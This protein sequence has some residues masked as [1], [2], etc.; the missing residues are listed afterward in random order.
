MIVDIHTHAFPDSVAA[1]A[2]EK[3]RSIA[4]EAHPYHDGRLSSLGESMRRAGIDCAAVCCVATRP[5]Q[6]PRIL[7]WCRLI[8]SDRFLPFPSVHPQDPQAVERLRHV[9][10]EGFRGVKLHPYY[11]D[12]DL[13]D[14][15]MD[16]I[17]ACLE[18]TGLIVVMHTGF[19]IAFPRV[20]RCD[21]Q[22]IV[23]V[24]SRFPRLRFVAAH[25]GGWADWDEV[26]KYLIGRPIFLEISYTLG[27][28]PQERVRSMILA[29]PRDRV[30]FGTDSP[31]Q[32]Q[33][34]TLDRLRALHLGENWE[35]AI[36]SAN[37]W[38][39]LGRR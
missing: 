26:E 32:D 18:E 16:P 24:L 36:L 21:P 2:L 13:D 35:Q 31:W 29:H 33:K 5:E 7:E 28:L 11:Q 12:F 9:A 8:A 4:P 20:R 3:L 22:R 25:L 23:R 17:Y 15:K 30:L 1:R 39:L 38:R 10:L 37:A 6:F 14:S 34:E 27:L 19:D